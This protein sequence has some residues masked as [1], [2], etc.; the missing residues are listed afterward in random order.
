MENSKL[1]RLYLRYGSVYNFAGKKSLPLLINQPFK[2]VAET[3]F[4]SSS[5]FY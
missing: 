2:N 1:Q 5:C 4:L 3:R